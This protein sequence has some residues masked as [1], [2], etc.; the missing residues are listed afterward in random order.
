PTDG[1]GLRC[2]SVELDDLC[3]PIRIDS[4]RIAIDTE[5]VGRR[6]GA[7]A[8]ELELTP[9]GGAVECLY[10]GDGTVKPPPGGRGVGP[11]ATSW[12]AR[13][14]LDGVASET[15]LCARLRLRPG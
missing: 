6:R 9:T 1:G 12:Q 4:Q 13:R 3:F 7:P 8:A 15:E 11:G 2:M 5:G 14:G 10:L